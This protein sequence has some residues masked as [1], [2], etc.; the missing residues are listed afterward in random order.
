M[1]ENFK[2]GFCFS[3][4]STT[5]HPV[6]F[7]FAFNSLAKLLQVRP[8]KKA[9]KGLFKYKCLSYLHC[10]WTLFSSVLHTEDKIMAENV[11]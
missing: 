1:K 6:A 9:I 8:V 11:Q 2:P 10:L 4:H 5:I 3:K 7:A